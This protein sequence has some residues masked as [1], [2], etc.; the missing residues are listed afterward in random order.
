MTLNSKCS[1]DGGRFGPDVEW[2]PE[3]VDAPGEDSY[4]VD[5]ARAA[6]FYAA[7]RRYWPGLPDGALVADYSGI[8]PKLRGAK[9]SNPD[10]FVFLGP[11]GTAR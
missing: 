5:P 8:R 1:C 11:G 7:I 10:E 2:L 3:S 9:S 4:Q 6:G